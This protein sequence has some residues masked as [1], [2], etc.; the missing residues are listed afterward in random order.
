MKTTDRHAEAKTSLSELMQMR[1]QSL[2]VLFIGCTGRSSRSTMAVRA[3]TDLGH[4]VKTIPSEALDENGERLYFDDLVFQ[5]MNKLGFPPDRRGATRLALDAIAKFDFDVLW[6][7]KSLGL[8]PQVLEAARKKA[9]WAKLVFHSEDDMFARH[10]QSAW[11]RRALPLYDVVFTHKSYNANPAELPALGARRV[12]MIDKCFDREVHCPVEVSDE[13]RERLSSRV[14][15]IGTFENERAQ[16]MLRLAQAGIEVRVWGNHWQGWENRHPNLR[17]EGRALVGTDYVKAVCSTEI[18]L[19]FL[20]RQNRD[21]QTDRSL[22]I[23]ACGA[24]MLA[25]RTGEHARLFK[26]GVE[27]EFFADFDELLQ[28]IEHYLHA[29]EERNT[30]GQRGRQ[31]C[32]ESG[33]SFHDRVGSM[34]R[35]AIGEQR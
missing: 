2:R 12:V 27:A 5:V 15:F 3:M 19:G 34:L 20:R 9:P 7:S 25:E 31:R 26:E 33:Y 32:L 11:F 10:N 4:D 35:I 14:G 17:V 22:E 13:E 1:L 24:L 16:T 8:R 6:V 28:K 23:P 21:L 30:I 18:N 29:P